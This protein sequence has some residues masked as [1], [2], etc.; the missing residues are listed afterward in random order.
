[1]KGLDRD[2]QTRG[3]VVNVLTGIAVIATRA[4]RLVPLLGLSLLTACGGGNWSGEANMVSVGGSVSGLTGAVVLRSGTGE[5]LTVTASGAFT[6]G[7]LVARDSAYSVTVATQPSGQYCTASAASGTATANVTSVRIECLSDV[8]IGGTVTGLT[9]T[10]ILQNNG[11]DSLAT[12][13]NGAFQFSAKVRAGGAYTV[14]VLSHP[15]SQTC[16]V[17]SGSGTATTHVSNVQVTC[18]TFA[19][20]ALPEIYRTGKPINYGPYRAA[21]PG[22]G[23]MPTDAQ[24]LEDL[25]LMESAGF[26][27]VRLFGSDDV[28]DKILRLAAA[29]ATSLKFQL[30]IYLQGAFAPSCDDPVNR[31]QI[32][33]GILLANSYANVVTVSVGNETSFANNLPVSCLEEYVRTVRSQ[34]TQPVTADDDFSFYAGRAANRSLPDAV[35][36]QVDFVAIHMYPL[37]NPAGWDWQQQAVPA[38]FDRAAAMMNAALDYSMEAYRAVS[39]YRYVGADGQLQQTGA[40]RPIV[41][42]ETGWKAVQTN[43]ASSIEAY[44]ARPANAKWYYDLM[45]GWEGSSGGPATIF[46]FVAFDEAWKGIDDGWG[47]WDAARRARY[48][49]CGT[50]AGEPCNAD[51]YTGAGYYGALPPASGS[52]AVLDFNTPGVTYSL[53]SFGGEYADLVTTGIPAGAP[54]GQVLRITRAAGSQC[55]A[56]TTVSVGEQA[57]IG[58]LPFAEN[59]KTLTAR[60]YVPEAGM[61]VKMKVEQAD[62]PAISAETDTVATAAGWQTLVF[63]FAATSPGT[64]TLNVANTYNKLSLFPNFSCA[65]GSS[66]ATDEV[67]YVGPILFIGATGPSEPPIGPP[68]ASSYTV[69]DFNTAGVTYGLTSFGGLD[70]QLSTS[71]VPAGGPTNQLV[72]MLR[73]AAAECY[74]GV[75][76]WTGNSDSIATLPFSATAKR[77]SLL[78]HSPVAGASIKLKAE[79]A[80]NPTLSVETDQVTAAGWQELVFDFSAPSPGTAALNTSIVYNKLTIF[81]SFSCGGAAPG[82]EQIFHLGPVTFLGAAAPAGPAL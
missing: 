72:R 52:Y 8:N 68:S 14:K 67:F 49:L 17:A 26:N 55:W 62:N 46:Y 10:V 16:T 45:R 31:A 77:I 56:G 11:T 32:A 7:L 23:E 54:A 40:T 39:D 30:G 25:Q 36:R 21:G 73:P 63:D 34:I 15:A 33:R 57:S 66:P 61:S 74:A 76:L 19:L 35:L 69:L 65:S 38:G 78:L 50:P 3:H 12:A 42:G 28:S 51:L 9:G 18:T 80:T 43:P 4:A 6:F 64:A 75:T 70:A 27:L 13:S 22:G 59:A 29:N 37:S 1:M 5:Q 79:N 53:T 44:A 58:R 2:R 47:V 41:V 60:I 48:A 20:R 82:A 24:V 81:P 71:N